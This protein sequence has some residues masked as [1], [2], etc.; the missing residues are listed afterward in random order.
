[1]FVD[2]SLVRSSY[3]QVVKVRVQS[4]QPGGVQGWEAPQQKSATGPEKPG[5]EAAPHVRAH[6]RRQALVCA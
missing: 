3:F 5:R 4:L 1:M 6:V 2:C